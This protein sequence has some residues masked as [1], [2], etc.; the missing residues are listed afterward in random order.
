[1]RRLIVS[2][3]VLAL[4]GGG[5]FWFVTAPT[6]LAPEATANLTGDAK[7]GEAVFWAAGCASCHMAEGA[8]AEAELVLTGGQKFPSDFGTFI[9]PNISPDP[10]HGIGAWSIET[11][12]NAVTR[13]VSPDG[14]HY[15]PAF[16]YNAYNKMALQDVVNLKAFMDTLPASTAPSQAHDVG[17]P[18]NIR[19]SL[20]GW[21]FLFESDDWVIDGDLTVEETRGRYLSEALAHCGECHTPRNALG[22]LERGEWLAGGLDPSGKGRIPN[23]TP[24]G[25]DWDEADIV[26]YLTSG[27]TPDYD[28]VGGHMVHV[29]EN[30]ARLPESDRAAVA[31]Y[32]KR[33]PA[34]AN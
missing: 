17:F 15:Y 14:S 28:S 11:F 1:M 8:E 16:P 26:G 6:P 29:V 21:K 31:A 33:V 9:A 2:A 13:G 24:A 20:G 18:F 25:L 3:S 32:L 12:A 4:I 30:M 19:R 34:V 23:I 22:G 7:A 5:V 10:T 27:F